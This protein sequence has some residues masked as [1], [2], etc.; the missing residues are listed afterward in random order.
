[1][2]KTNGCLLLPAAL[3]LLAAC[4]SGKKGEDAP[5]DMEMHQQQGVEAFV[6]T[7]VLHQTEFNKQIVCNGK[8]AAKAKSEI[9][10]T[11]QGVIADVMVKEGQRVSK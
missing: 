5:K 2:I 10:F 3:V 8:L 6:D 7:M 1:M 4:N 9:N 11:G